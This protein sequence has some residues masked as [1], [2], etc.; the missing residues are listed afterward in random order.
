[1]EVVKMNYE[2][3]NLEEKIIVG[4]SV[5]TSNEDPSFGLIYIKVASMQTSRIR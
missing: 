1:M 3:V 5:T 4:V 2:I